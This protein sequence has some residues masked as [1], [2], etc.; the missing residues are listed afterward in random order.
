MVRHCNEL[1]TDDEG[2]FLGAMPE[3]S[4][5]LMGMIAVAMIDRIT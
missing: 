1:S 5:W 2:E 3:P 4:K